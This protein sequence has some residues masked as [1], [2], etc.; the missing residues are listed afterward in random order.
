MELIKNIAVGAAICAP[1]VAVFSGL[2]WFF[3]P[4]SIGIILIGI[5][6]TVV[7]GAIGYTLRNTDWR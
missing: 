4:A 1:I 3:G 6:I 2:F 7:C 5:F